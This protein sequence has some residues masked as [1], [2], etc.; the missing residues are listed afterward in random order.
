MVAI[1]AVLLEDGR[2]VLGERDLLRRVRRRSRHRKSNYR[3]Q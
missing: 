2:H 3:Y 1:L